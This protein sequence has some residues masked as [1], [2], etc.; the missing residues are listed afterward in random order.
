LTAFS[1]PRTAASVWG[2]RFRGSIIEAHGG[3]IRADNESVYG[4]ARFSNCH[5]PGEAAAV[6]EAAEG[7]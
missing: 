4:G 7:A 6:S 3:H 1:R 2:C 5:I